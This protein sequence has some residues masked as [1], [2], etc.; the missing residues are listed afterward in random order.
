MMMAN[1]KPTVV[2]AAVSAVARPATANYTREQCDLVKRTV[3]RN[4][5]DDEL[6][7][8]LGTAQRLGLDPFTK[9]IYSIERWNSETGQK[10]RQ[11]QI[12]I[13]GFRVVAER[14]GKYLPGPKPT[15]E[16]D[17]EGRILSC[18]A[19]VLKWSALD[20]EWHPIEAECAYEEF[21]QHRKDGK[22]TRMW[23]QMPR[24]MLSRSAESL[25][26]R[27]AF[28]M[29]LGGVCLRGDDVDDGE[30]G[31]EKENHRERSETEDPGWGDGRRAGPLVGKFKEAFRAAKTQD[32]LDAYAKDLDESVRAGVVS[33]D[34]RVVLV[35]VYVAEKVRLAAAGNAAASP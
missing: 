18:V 19:T 33:P 31:G 3:C 35:E 22:P 16:V 15:F 26:L 12:G 6:A 7:L 20:S 1:E 28:P 23:A 34:E 11:I 27:R 9:Q 17:G 32:E 13:D 8:F 30:H 2:M 14:T 24:V 25:A 29:D 21:V 10:E 5:T 4:A